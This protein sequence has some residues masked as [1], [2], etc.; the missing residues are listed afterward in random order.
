MAG[1]FANILAALGI[2]SDKEPVTEAHLQAADEKI[3]ALEQAKTDADEKLATAE[4]ALKT[5]QAEQTKIAGE[6]KTAADKVA[7]LET[8]KKNQ[9]TVDGREEDD[10][11]KLDGAPEAQ[12]PWEKAASS[13]IASAKKRLGD[14]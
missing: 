4:T 9:A 5:A 1:K 14:K 3:A 2:G 11:N 13:A 10:S 8:W 6:L 12:E 7:T